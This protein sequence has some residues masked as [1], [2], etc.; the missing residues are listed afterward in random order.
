MNYSQNI[1][2]ANEQKVKRISRTKIR[3]RR[4]RHNYITGS[5]KQRENC[6]SQRCLH[7]ICSYCAANNE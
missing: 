5:M 4:N 6:F 7:M 2:Q 3:K 1:E